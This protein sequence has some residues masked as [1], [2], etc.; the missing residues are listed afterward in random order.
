VYCIFWRFVVDLIRDKKQDKKMYQ[1]ARKIGSDFLAF[2][3]IGCAG[4]TG[5]IL[6]VCFPAFM[7]SGVRSSQVARLASGS[8][9]KKQEKS[10]SKTPKKRQKP[11]IKT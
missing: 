6:P 5:K 9:Q 7:L 10:S 3:F 2:S 4:F 8:R 11:N 1:A